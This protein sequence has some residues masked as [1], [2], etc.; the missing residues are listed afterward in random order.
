MTDL[1]AA[2]RRIFP[3]AGPRRRL[4]VATFV[5]T[6]GAGMFMT[7]SALF[8]THVVG[9]PDGQVALGLGVGGL[10]GLAAGIAGGRMADRIGAR[11]T[12]VVAMVLGAGGMACFTLVFDF[13][14]YL[15]INAV[16]AALF[17]V[18]QVAIIPMTR[19]IG[20]GDA[21]HYRAYLRSVSNLAVSV[22]AAIAGIAIQVDTEPAYLALVFGRAAALVA[23]ALVLRGLPEARAILRTAP[24]WTAVRDIRYLWATVVNGLMSIRFALLGFALPLWVV[25]HTAAP[26]WLVAASFVLN[27]T[28]VVLF[29]VRASREVKDVRSAG[30]RMRWAG[31]AL[32]VAMVLIAATSG[33]SAPVAVVLLLSSVVLYTLG[34]LWHAAASMEFMY[35]LAPAAA[36]GEYAGVFNLG[37][38][39]ARSVAP[40]VF[41]MTALD[42]GLLGWLLLGLVF[43]GAGLLAGPLVAGRVVRA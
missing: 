31:L 41:G 9:L 13:W 17:S 42:W 16:N 38:G 19:R 26:R 3:E 22:G 12:L 23:C 39:L 35:G 37:V 28:L 29:Q 14:S 10:V 15:L 11:R 30:V 8:F 40:A 20:E 34:D 4:T 21:V 1:A 2:P 7:S 18:A 5:N 36:Q 6:A 33:V 27:T 24:K 32:L 25:D 43:A